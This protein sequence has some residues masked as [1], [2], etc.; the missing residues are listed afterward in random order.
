MLKVASLIDILRGS[1]MMPEKTTIVMFYGIKDPS[2]AS[3]VCSLQE[4]AAQ[5]LGKQFLPRPLDEVH[6]T[7]IGLER[8]ES[9]TLDQTAEIV[10]Y[11]DCEFR[12]SLLVQF[13]GFEDKDYVFSSRGERLYSRSLSV[14]GNDLVLIGWPVNPIDSQPDLELDRIR[15]ECQAYGF[16]YKYYDSPGA[17]D[18]D[19]Y[20]TIGDIGEAVNESD[21]E[22]LLTQGRLL[23]SEKPSKLNTD[24]S[25]IKLAIYEDRRLPSS[26]TR[27]VALNRLRSAVDIKS[28]L[29]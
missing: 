6:A 13:G 28:F 21:I 14:V 18:P 24:T 5:A 15:H 10:A 9:A 1:S 12:K 27:T 11:L 25:S 16:R 19:C 23:L 4:L 3:L 26:S 20:M 8:S 2:L 22:R 17:V 7:L 29:S